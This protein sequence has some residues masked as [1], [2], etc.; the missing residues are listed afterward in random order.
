MVEVDSDYFLVPLECECLL[1]FLLQEIPLD[2][3]P[4]RIS[5]AIKYR[6]SPQ[7]SEVLV[8][9]AFA[10]PN[11]NLGEDGQAEVENQPQHGTIIV[12]KL[13]SEAL[14]MSTSSNKEVPDI[15]LGSSTLGTDSMT[16]DMSLTK[17]FSSKDEG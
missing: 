2:M 16:S 5:M 4:P 6:Q 13:V 11:K 8:K 17:V 9:N 3:L 12:D 10:T 14:P 7:I 1:A 15:P